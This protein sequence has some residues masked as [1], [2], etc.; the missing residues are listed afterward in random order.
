MP[1]WIGVLSLQ[2]IRALSLYLCSVSHSL[3]ANEPETRASRAQEE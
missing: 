2:D 3:P 1:A